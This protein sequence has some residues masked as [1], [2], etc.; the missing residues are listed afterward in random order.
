MPPVPADAFAREFRALHAADRTAFVAALWSARGWETSI[1]DGR[2]SEAPAGQTEANASVD[3]VVLAERDGQQRRIGVVDPGRFWTP[4]LSGLDTL[5]ATRGREAVRTAASETGVEYVSP[6]DLRDLLLYGVERGVAEDLYEQHVGK[7][8]AREVREETEESGEAGTLLP[9]IPTVDVGRRALAVIVILALVGV[10]FAGPGLPGSGPEQAPITVGNVTPEDGTVG[11]VG[12]G[13]PEPTGGP[14]V[15]PGV[16]L[17]G[18]ESGMTLADAHVAGVQNRSRVLHTELHAFPSANGTRG[19]VSRNATSVIVNESY[20]RHESNSVLTGRNGT[21]NSSVSLYADGETV[22]DRVVFGDDIDYRARSVE[23]APATNLD[24]SVQGYLYRYFVSAEDSV[25]TCAI[26]YDT[27]CP[28]YRIAVDNPPDRLGENIEDYDGLLIVSDRGVITT[29]RASYTV[30]D[31][32][33]DGEREQIR[34]ALDYRFEEVG[35]TE[36]DWLPRAKNA[37]ADG[38][39]TQTPTPSG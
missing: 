16:S 30:P 38:T 26:E 19:V 35:P 14:N 17:D 22:Y 8:L 27:D 33:G 36:P 29:I 3:G 2:G 12:V 32:D 5:V 39:A 18:V 37:S 21:I 31:A 25:V 7:P 23:E 24:G 6:V 11:A 9:A 4:D 20:Y 28:T 34:F 10:A 1:D 15:A 13:T